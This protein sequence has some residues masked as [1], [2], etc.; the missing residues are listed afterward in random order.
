MRQIYEVGLMGAAVSALHLDDYINHKNAMKIALL[1]LILIAS[2][3]I[4]VM[5]QYTGGSGQ[6]YAMSNTVLNQTLPV[7]WLEFRAEFLNGEVILRWAT[8]SELN[9]DYFELQHSINGLQFSP[10]AQVKGNGTTRQIMRYSYI[11]TN[12]QIGTNYYRLRQVDFDGQFDY[13]AILSVACAAN[14][15]LSLQ[16]YPNPASNLINVLLPYPAN[17][18]LIVY[19]ADGKAV[20]SRPIGNERHIAIDVSGLQRGLYAMVCKMGA[21]SLSG[22]FVVE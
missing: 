8:A 6:G 11:D 7:A 21:L 12:P 10:I 22:R 15:D 18:F 14:S 20:M 2:N 17:A 9:N 16:F 19:N 13:S 4:T 5:A 1:L 3:A